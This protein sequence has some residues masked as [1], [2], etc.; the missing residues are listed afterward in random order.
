MPTFNACAEMR[1]VGHSFENGQRKRGPLPML[2]LMLGQHALNQIER[3]ADSGAIHPLTCTPEPYVARGR[4][5]MRWS[6]R[7]SDGGDQH[8]WLTSRPKLVCVF[9]EDLQDV[10]LFFLGYFCDDERVFGQ[11]RL[12]L[13]AQQ[14]AQV[15][16]GMASAS[17]VDAT[18]KDRR[19]LSLRGF[20]GKSN[21]VICS[22]LMAMRRKSS[23]MS[24]FRCWRNS[25]SSATSM[26]RRQDRSRRH[27]GFGR[28]VHRTARSV[29]RPPRRQA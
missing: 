20:V 23:S 3:P 2:S 5:E 22:S 6:V 25:R 28:A 8:S 19:S 12:D 18:C 11:Q 10:P 14:I 4:A 16:A 27:R 1:R 24:E 13:T 17:T 15:S 21:A 26:T 29:T 7:G 9:R